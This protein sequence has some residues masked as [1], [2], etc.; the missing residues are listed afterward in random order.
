MSKSLISET[1]Q[2]RENEKAV[3]N[4]TVRVASD[5]S[6]KSILSDFS[7]TFSD[8]SSSEAVLKQRKLQ[9]HNTIDKNQQTVLRRLQQ[10]TLERT[11]PLSLAKLLNF[12]KTPMPAWK[13]LISLITHYFPPRGETTVQVFDFG[14]EHATRTEIRLGDVEKGMKCVALPL[15]C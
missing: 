2:D 11:Q 7:R 8:Q 12:R 14:D 4:V 1:Q 3:R 6:T 15:M 10:W 9:Y 5:V 13:E